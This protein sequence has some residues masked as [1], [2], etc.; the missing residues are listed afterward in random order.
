MK[1][2]KNKGGGFSKCIRKRATAWERTSGDE[3][4]GKEIRRSSVT[5]SISTSMKSVRWNN[6][7]DPKMG[8]NNRTGESAITAASSDGTANAISF[9]FYSKWIHATPCI[10][11]NIKSEKKTCKQAN[12]PV[13]MFTVGEHSKL[14]VRFSEVLE[15]FATEELWENARSFDYCC[16]SS[17]LG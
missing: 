5:S 3:F 2:Y 6:V 14:E 12:I 10:P 8:G 15:S 11:Q 1:F 13:P 7:T 17:T 16:P 4:E 9:P